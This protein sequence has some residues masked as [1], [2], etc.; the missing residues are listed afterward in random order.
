MKE[1]INPTELRLHTMAEFMGFNTD[2][3]WWTNKDQ[4]IKPINIELCE[5]HTSWNALMH[6]WFKFNK[7]FFDQAIL[8]SKHEQLCSIIR[9]AILEGPKMT[10]EQAFEKLSDGIDWYNEVKVRLQQG[11]KVLT[12]MKSI[13]T[14]FEVIPIGTTHKQIVIQ[15]KGGE[16]MQATI[17]KA[18]PNYFQLES[19]VAN[20][21]L[22]AKSNLAHWILNRHKNRDEQ[23]YELIEF[24][25]EHIQ[26]DNFLNLK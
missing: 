10:P 22:T 13:I 15:I 11:E 26:E 3:H 17:D 23:I 20:K 7:L 12:A 24:Q 2:S 8:N 18:N 1:Q 9:Y 25:L 14:K 6:V 19:E 4:T 16:L 5:Y 21:V